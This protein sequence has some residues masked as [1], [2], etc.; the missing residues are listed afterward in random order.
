MK[1]SII[2]IVH[3]EI[4]RRVYLIRQLCND[5]LAHLEA[6]IYK[7]GVLV[8]FFND[9]HLSVKM[10]AAIK[11]PKIKSHVSIDKPI[12]IPKSL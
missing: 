10:F 2:T 4:R 1:L 5:L 11:F 9:M 7:D 12:L 8:I 6:F 3:G